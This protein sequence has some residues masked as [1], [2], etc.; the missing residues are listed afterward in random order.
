MYGKEEFENSYLFK[1]AGRS[2]SLE[3]TGN[4]NSTAKQSILKM[5][6]AAAFSN[7]PQFIH[8]AEFGK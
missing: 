6:N 5:A 8:Q 2:R 7:N 4:L 1:S 3:N